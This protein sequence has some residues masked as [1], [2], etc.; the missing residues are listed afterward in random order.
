MSAREPFCHL[1]G[2]DPETLSKE[3]N[4]LL[5]AELFVRVC[6]ELIDI[7]KKEYLGYFHV[8][9]FTS[10]MEHAMLETNLI[11]LIINDLLSTGEYTLQG[12]AYY[13]DTH[14]DVLCELA[15][16]LNTKP[17]AI[18][19]LKVIEL[20]RIARRDIYC[21]IGKKLASEYLQRE[22]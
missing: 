1:I 20:H 4:I 16:G 7:F 2:V 3:E 22:V 13:A 17:L 18:C 8:M 5:E 14:E 15:S 11:R 9:N 6:H 12:I 21:S 10:E 19:L